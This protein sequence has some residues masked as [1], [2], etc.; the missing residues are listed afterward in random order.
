MAPLVSWIGCTE[1]LWSHPLEIVNYKRTQKSYVSYRLM[2]LHLYMHTT[3]VYLLV[4]NLSGNIQVPQ[5][6]HYLQPTPTPQHKCPQRAAPPQCSHTQKDKST[7]QAQIAYLPLSTTKT[8]SRLFTVT[9][10]RAKYRQHKTRQALHLAGQNQKKGVSVLPNT[11]R[12][13][14]PII[15]LHPLSARRR[16]SLPTACTLRLRRIVSKGQQQSKQA[17]QEDDSWSIQC[18]T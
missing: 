17:Q 15:S 13:I 12:P 8:P 14:P 5:R 9:L 2:H 6:P 3:I 1:R 18:D 4:T 11:A 16:C 7:A 10:G